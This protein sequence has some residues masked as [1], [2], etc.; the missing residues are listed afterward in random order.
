MRKYLTFIEDHK[1]M[2]WSCDLYSKNEYKQK[3]E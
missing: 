1:L 3:S 2:E